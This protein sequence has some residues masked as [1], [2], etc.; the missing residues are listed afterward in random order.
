MYPNPL[1]GLKEMWAHSLNEL[2]NAA[3]FVSIN[4]LR[5]GL[6][7]YAPFNETFNFYTRLNLGPCKKSLKTTMRIIFKNILLE[8]VVELGSKLK[9][10]FGEYEK[11]L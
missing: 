1:E 9:F 3:N 2:K 5:P 6:Y 11:Y 7:N 8:K 10:S 4:L